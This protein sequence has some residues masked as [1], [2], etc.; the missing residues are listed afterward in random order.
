MFLVF[1]KRYL[2]LFFFFS[3]SLM[4]RVGEGLLFSQDTTINFFSPSSEFNN[5]R[6]VSVVA[7][8]GLAYAGTIVQLSNTWYKDYYYHASF[9]FFNDGNEWLQMDKAGHMLTSYYLG[10]MG[11]D[12]MEWSGANQKKNILLGGTMGFAFLSTVEILDGFSQGWGF[13]WGDF[14]ANTIGSGLIIGKNLLQHKTAGSPLQRGGGAISL[15]F[16][17]S[18]TDYPKYRPS[19]LGKNLTEQ[20]LKDYNGQSYWM[21]FNISSFFGVGRDFKSRLTFPKWLNVAFGYGAERMISGKPDFVY[22]D[23]QGNVIEFERYRQYY[24]SLDID[25]TRIKTRSHFLKTLFETIAFI[26]F[27]APALE[28]NKHGLKFH[29]LYY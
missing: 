11:I 1:R 24:L 26:K 20:W 2:L 23:A 8:Q 10:R 12:M 6:Y 17:F 16:S 27:P 3:S 9:H 7:F 22:T 13:S 19:L 21:S 18:Q 14:S 4:G 15:K 5:K 29:A 25:L 28:M